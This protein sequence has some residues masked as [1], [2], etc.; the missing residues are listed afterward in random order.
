MRMKLVYAIG[1]AIAALPALSGAVMAASPMP[2]S[3][4]PSTQVA[5]TSQCPAGTYWEASGYVSSGKWR[6]AHCAVDNGRQ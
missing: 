5:A 3:Q 1:F 4:T 6:S 2:A